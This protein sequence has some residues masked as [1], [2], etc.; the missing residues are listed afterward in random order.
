MS[1]QFPY[2]AQHRLS[3][4]SKPAT[5]D[6]LFQETSCQTSW[7][8]HEVSLRTLWLCIQCSLVELGLPASMTSERIHPCILLTSHNF[9][10]LENRTRCSIAV[11]LHPLKPKRKEMLKTSLWSYSPP[12]YACTK[13]WGWRNVTW[14]LGKK[15]ADYTRVSRCRNVLFRPHRNTTFLSQTKCIDWVYIFKISV[16]IA[17]GCLRRHC[18]KYHKTIYILRASLNN[19]LLK[20]AFTAIWKG[21]IVCVHPQQI[22]QNNHQL[23]RHSLKYSLKFSTHLFD[24][25]NF[26][27]CSRHP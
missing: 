11:C 27:S 21:L 14:S 25:V 22:N 16:I 9:V 24:T 1:L 4:R 17:C 8:V 19:R 2:K 13:W 23:F 7:T 12:F 3:S 10:I 20:D 18:F 26:Q 15:T 5:R 6:T